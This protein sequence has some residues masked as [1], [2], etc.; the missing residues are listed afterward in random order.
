MRHREHQWRVAI[1]CCRC[2]YYAN[3]AFGIE[4]KP[5]VRSVF[6]EVRRPATRHRRAHTSTRYLNADGPT[7]ERV[8]RAWS[9]QHEN[10]A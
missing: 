4:G 9:R 5:V 1:E 2:T 10:D 3:L 6:L 7:F 8:V